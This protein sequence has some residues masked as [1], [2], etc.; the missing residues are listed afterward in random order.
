MWSY[1]NIRPAGGCLCPPQVRLSRWRRDQ[2]GRRSPLVLEQVL[3]ER[4]RLKL[5][6]SRELGSGER[7]AQEGTIGLCD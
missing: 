7:Q 5:F 3:A 4:W 6:A 1:W 2:K